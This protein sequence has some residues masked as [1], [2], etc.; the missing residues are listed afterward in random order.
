MVNDIG[1]HYIIVDTEKKNEAMTL[2]YKCCWSLHAAAL[3]PSSSLTR[4]GNTDQ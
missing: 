2:Q 4:A 3:P 1:G